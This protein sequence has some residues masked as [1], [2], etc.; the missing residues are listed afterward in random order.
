MVWRKWRQHT[1]EGAFLPQAKLG[2]SPE[3]GKEL[4]SQSCALISPSPSGPTSRRSAVCRPT[5][6]NG[7]PD[8]VSFLAV[9][10]LAS[11]I[12]HSFGVFRRENRLD[13]LSLGPKG[14]LPLPPRPGP[15]AESSRISLLRMSR[16][17]QPCRVG[18]EC[19]T[20][21]QCFSKIHSMQ[22]LWPE[23][24]FPV[25]ERHVTRGP[26][27]SWS[28]QSWSVRATHGRAGRPPSPAPAEVTALPAPT[29]ACCRLHRS[30]VG[31]K[32][33]AGRG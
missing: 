6:N 16:Q 22:K 32:R 1:Q 18:W 7:F 24:N 27:C 9:L 11:G 33:P 30:G 17:A 26:G 3:P 23:E 12:A 10:F 19:L 29:P 31:D 20:R 28:G 15:R 2:S 8:C 21:C 13:R 4:S 5:T 25:T 14:C